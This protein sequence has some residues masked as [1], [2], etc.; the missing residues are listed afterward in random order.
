MGSSQSSACDPTG[1]GKVAVC[2][3]SNGRTAISAIQQVKEL[4][5]LVVFDL[6]GT[7]AESKSSLGFLPVEPSLTN[8]WVDVTEPVIDK[9]DGM[10][11]RHDLHRGC[12]FSGR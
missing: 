9:V 10:V 6:D 7:L 8:I 4:K 5:K 3:H 2:F 11:N 12:P 1:F